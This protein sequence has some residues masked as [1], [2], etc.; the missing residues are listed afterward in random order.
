MANSIHFQ[1]RGVSVPRIVYTSKVAYHRS[2]V[3]S[4][5]VHIQRNWG[6]GVWEVPPGSRGAEQFVLFFIYV[7]ICLYIIILFTSLFT[8]VSTYVYICLHVVYTFFQFPYIR[9]YNSSH[10]FCIN[11]PAEWF[12]GEL[13]A[14]IDLSPGLCYASSVTVILNVRSAASSEVK[15]MLKPVEAHPNANATKPPTM[16]TTGQIRCNIFGLYLKGFALPPTRQQIVLVFEI[17]IINLTVFEQFW[18]FH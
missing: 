2:C 18:G 6:R 8:Y 14:F 9:F 11:T 13:K 10:L 16:S 1:V 5:K 7:A 4:L 3:V 15:G 17:L 12:I